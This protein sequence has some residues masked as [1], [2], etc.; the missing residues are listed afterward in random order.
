MNKQ[1]IKGGGVFH[2]RPPFSLMVFPE[3]FTETVYEQ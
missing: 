1:L 3:G 2:T